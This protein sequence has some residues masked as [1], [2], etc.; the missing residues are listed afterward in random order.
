MKLPIKFTG[1]YEHCIMSQAWTYLSFYFFKQKTNQKLPSA[2]GLWWWKPLF[3]IIVQF[4][5][6]VHIHNYI[7]TIKYNQKCV[8]SF[9]EVKIN[10]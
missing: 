1:N 8:F 6:Q 7:L 5:E 3:L 2:L 9:A 4:Y 10:K